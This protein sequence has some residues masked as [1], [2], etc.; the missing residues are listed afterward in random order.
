MYINWVL[1]LN[2]GV[3]VCRV[4][5]MARWW[6]ILECFCEVCLVMW[7]TLTR[8][9]DWMRERQYVF[10]L[11]DTSWSP[12]WRVERLYLYRYGGGNYATRIWTRCMTWFFLLVRVWMMV[13][14]WF[15]QGLREW[16]GCKSRMLGQRKAV[17]VSLKLSLNAS[18]RT[19][20]ENSACISS[21]SSN[22]LGLKCNTLLTPTT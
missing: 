10:V 21:I 1:W 22:M 19:Q 5:A 11:V 12:K 18:C 16:T 4:F 14:V 7:S 3:L 6:M 9:R 20:E 17:G 8:D 2:S 13:R 15:V